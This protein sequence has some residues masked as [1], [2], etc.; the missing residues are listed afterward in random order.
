MAA[1]SEPVIAFADPSRHHQ[2]LTER[3]DTLRR[4]ENF[5]DVTVAVK[6][7]EF[8]A[9]KVVLAA[10]SPFFLSLLESNMR[11]SNEQVIRI[12][13]EEATAPVMEDVL[14][15]VYTGNVS[16][17]EESGHNLIA[18]ADYLLLPGLKT[19]AGNF[20]KENVTIDNCISNYYFA[21]KYQCE[22]LRET[23]CKVITSN[24]SVVMETDD[25]LNLDTKQVMEWVSSDDITVSAEEEVFKGIVKWVTHNKSE[26]DSD[27]PDLLRQVRLMSLSHDFLFDKLIKQELITTN[28]DCLNFVLRSMEYIFRASGGTKPPRKC[29]EK[30]MDGIFVCGGRK[31]FCYLPHESKWYQMVDMSMEHQ[32]HAAVQYRGKIYIFSRQAVESGQ[33]DIA[34][35][36]LP[37]INSWGAIQR[38]FGY[39]E[40]FSSLL[41]LN[42][43]MN[44]YVL[45]NTEIAPEN[46]IFTFNP[47]KNEWKVQGGAAL[48]RWGA[49]GVTDGHHIYIIGGTMDDDDAEVVEVNA[50]A[51]VERLDPIGDCWEEVAAMNEARHDA[52]GAAMNGK[53]YVAGGMQK[54]GEICTVLNTC[55]VYDPSTNEWQVMPNLEMP[56]CFASMVCFEEA[57]YIIAGLKDDSKS[58]ELSVETFDSEKNEWKVIS[59]IPVSCE[60]EE[61]RRENIHFKACF[62]TVHKDVLKKPIEAN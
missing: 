17:T 14:K 39:D 36:Y 58:R 62:A 46:T 24:F 1:L 12:E 56:R 3:L 6:C 49:C 23:C 29:L 22:V 53:I 32:E 11:E 16:V 59:T 25:F 8:K 57:L 45:T 10:A 42:D 4:N 5:C 35:Y 15:Y 33:S 21:D 47:D 30:C 50:T 44:L 26:R 27:F 9:H 13:L 20:M 7:T 51:T 18:T 2:E 41:V 34:E 31:T 52:F 28:T 61:E 38:N 19:V 60:N 43:V 54:N 40:Q 48:A 37:S 55:E